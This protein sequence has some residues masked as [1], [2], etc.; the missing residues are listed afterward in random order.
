[1]RRV[2]SAPT[3]G[4][5]KTIDERWDLAA[6]GDEPDLHF[7]KGYVTGP[8]VAQIELARAVCRTCPLTGVDGPCLTRQLEHE[9]GKGRDY[10]H[11][12]FAGYTPGQRHAMDRS[13]AAGEAA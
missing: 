8:D 7:P 4:Y 6:C 13:Q 11:G 5:L 9:A 1:M 2:G 3:I 12:I 10:K